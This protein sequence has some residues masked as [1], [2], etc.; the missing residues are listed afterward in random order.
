[1]SPS[2]KTAAD[3]GEQENQ[4]IRCVKRSHYP[5]GFL[6]P[7]VEFSLTRMNTGLTV[8]TVKSLTLVLP[9]GTISRIDSSR[10][11][12]F[13][14]LKGG[15]NRFGIVTAVEYC[16]HTQA[17]KIYVSRYF[18]T[19][20]QYTNGE[21]FWQGGYAIYAPTSTSEIIN[22]TS[23]F[24]TDNNDSRAQIIT[25]LSGSAVGTTALV[26]FFFDGPSRPASF[27]PFD[28]ISPLVDEVK[29]QDF[30][31]FVSSI[32]S[33]L[34]EVANFR[35]SFNTM[36]TLRL[37]PGFLEAVRNE[38]DVSIDLVAISAS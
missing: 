22:A 36:C 1:M 25:T 19:Q 17:A 35:G 6:L 29:P 37:T 2:R 18:A 30:S 13:F 33:N 32:P 31:S 27:A 3:F 10:P 20:L 8:D 38:T 24:Y 4:P 15:L 34:A 14:A 9:N 28:G 16:T 11:E 12:L 5:Q 7:L 26:L 21:G 23:A